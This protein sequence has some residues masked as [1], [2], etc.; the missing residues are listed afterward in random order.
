[1]ATV[2]TLLRKSDNQHSSGTESKY[3]G[4]VA[5]IANAEIKMEE[6]QTE[7]ET[8]G[9]NINFVTATPIMKLITC[10]KCAFDEVRTAVTKFPIREEAKSG[11]KRTASG[12]ATTNGK[13]YKNLTDYG[14]TNQIFPYYKV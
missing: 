10:F 4:F 8:K 2:F 1:M 7:I 14:L 9:I 13:T 11:T 5:K 12:A 3:K 6:L